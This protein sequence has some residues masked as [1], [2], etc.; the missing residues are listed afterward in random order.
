MGNEPLSFIPE[1][2]PQEGPQPGPSWANGRWPLDDG[3]E[4]VQAMDP[5]AMKLAVR[6]AAA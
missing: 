6:D 1:L 2:G 5:T 3:G 4:L